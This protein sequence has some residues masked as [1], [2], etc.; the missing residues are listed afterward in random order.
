MAKKAKEEQKS[1]GQQTVKMETMI[2][3]TLIAL[4]LGFFAGE[5][6]DFSGPDRSA[7]VQ[8]P[9]MPQQPPSTPAPTADQSTR[10]LALEQEVS[11]NPGNAESWTELANLYYDSHQFEQAIRAY[12]KS[13]E[14]SPYD[15]NVWTD[16]GVMYRRNKQPFEAVGAFNK[17]IDVD[18]RHE[19]SRI[20]KGI[21]L[22]H[23]LDDREGA[24]EAWESLLKVNPSAKLGNGQP[25]SEIVEK[26]KQPPTQ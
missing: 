24:I 21:V 15:A 17:A 11:A 9:S 5:L 13:V 12:K 1:Q 19:I 26:L 18:P 14:L 4:I 7:P 3:V 2:I 6:I 22:L 8:P 20:N 23:D 16:L 25:V 10:I